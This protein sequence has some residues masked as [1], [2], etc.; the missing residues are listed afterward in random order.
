[1][2]DTDSP[3]RRD[4]L[5]ESTAATTDERAAMTPA[6][7]GPTLEQYVETRADD[8]TALRLEEADGAA[9]AWISAAAPSE[10]AQ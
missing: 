8:A 2:S 4:R 9:G 6:R 3:R 10:N 1:M 5:R 7:P